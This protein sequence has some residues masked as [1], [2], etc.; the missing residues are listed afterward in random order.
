M[1]IKYRKLVGLLVVLAVVCSLVAITAAPTSAALFTAP[2]CASS[3]GSPYA[4]FTDQ[5]AYPG[6]SIVGQ[7]GNFTPGAA[8]TVTLNG[9]AL[10]AATSV[11]AGTGASPYDWP[12]GTWTGS[13]TIPDMP[14]GNYTSALG[15]GLVATDTALSACADWFQVVPK[16]KSSP[17]TIGVGGTVTLTGRG[18]TYPGTA[19]A[20]LFRVSDGAPAGALITSPLPISVNSNGTFSATF[21]MPEP[22]QKDLHGNYT[23]TVT[24]SAGKNNSTNILLTPSIQLIPSNALPGQSFTVQGNDFPA[25]TAYIFWQAYVAGQSMGNQ[26]ISNGGFNV[27]TNIPTTA[28]VGQYYVWAIQG[29]NDS[30]PPTTANSAKALMT[31][32]VLGITLTPSSATAGTTVTLQGSGF[33]PGQGLSTVQF[34]S[35]PAP[36]TGGAG[37]TQPIPAS[38]TATVTIVVPPLNP[39]TYTVIATDTAAVFRTGSWTVGTPTVT[40]N[41]PAGPLSTLLTVSGSGWVPTT[42]AINY[43]L[44]S[45]VQVTMAGQTLTSQVSNAGK[46]SLTMLVPPGATSG[47]NSVLVQDMVTASGAWA[48]SPTNFSAVGTFTVTAATIKLSPNQGVAGQTI[49]FTGGGFPAYSQIIEIDFNQDIGTTIINPLPMPQVDGNGNVTGTFVVPASISGTATVVIW[50]TGWAGAGAA[51]FNIVSGAAT[52]AAVLAPLIT[53]NQLTKPVWSFDNV[54]KTWKMYDPNDLV[55]STITLFTPGTIYCLYVNATVSLNWGINS[56]SLTPGWNCIG[57]LG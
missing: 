57:W 41:P 3:G 19:T 55:D 33:T 51:T 17:A 42:N 10:T 15:N 4:N 39:G 16:L 35:V 52:P 7:G 44:A 6:Q 54:S 34:G 49:T 45:T 30:T 18:Y 40:L 20:A 31:V 11:V 9:I 47:P 13:F 22:L 1:S 50:S 12:S 56:Y 8:I 27:S 53:N 5:S 24:D 38:G 21:T 14:A 28:T 46:F 29:S 36:I 48:P 25:G 37:W 43:S 32:G 26:T 23:I 2:K